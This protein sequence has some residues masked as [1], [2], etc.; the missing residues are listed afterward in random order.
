MFTRLAKFR[1]FEPRRMASRWCGV[2]H[3]NDNLPDRRRPAGERRSPPPAL[4]CRWYLN[5][6][7][8]RLECRWQTA[9][10]EEQQSITRVI[11][12]TKPT[13]RTPFVSARGS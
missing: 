11:W 6:R 4:A 3:S 9:E 13:R 8:G 2:M 7:D 10:L 1:P 5:D 12:L